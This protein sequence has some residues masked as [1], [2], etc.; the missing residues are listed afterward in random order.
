M[1]KV[2]SKHV[3]VL[4]IACF[5]EVETCIYCTYSDKLLVYKY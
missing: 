5:Y 2:V 3:T 1:Q 4:D